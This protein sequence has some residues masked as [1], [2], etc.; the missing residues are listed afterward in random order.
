MLLTR[1]QFSSKYWINIECDL[2]G[3]AN[4]FFFIFRIHYQQK[5]ILIGQI[6]FNE[7]R[8]IVDLDGIWQFRIQIVI[9][10][11]DAHNWKLKIVKYLSIFL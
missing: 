2:C 7:G 9:D 5:F 10:I 4:A 8:K 6:S 3:K 1:R 11:V